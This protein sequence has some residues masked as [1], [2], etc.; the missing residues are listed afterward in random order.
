MVSDEK[1]STKRIVAIDGDIPVYSIGFASEGS[2]VEFALHSVKKLINKCMKG[3]KADS[4][5]IFLTGKGNFRE[6]RATLLPYKG[7]RKSEKPEHYQA[8]RDYLVDKHGAIVIDGAEADDALGIFLTEEDT[9]VEKIIATLDKDL[10]GVPGEHY[11]WKKDE[12]YDVSLEEA[13]HFFC[14]QLLTGDPTDNIPGLY[15][16]S[17][18]KATKKIKDRILPEETFVNQVDEVIDIYHEAMNEASSQP[19]LY[20]EVEE[21]VKEIGDLLWMHRDGEE[22]WWKYYQKQP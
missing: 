22:S 15:K 11:N 2:P 4:Y 6:E 16:V 8:I 3:A 13:D 9:G 19:I 10:N 14:Q 5:I 18:Q 12:L 20:K 21:I 7:N 1:D 17:G